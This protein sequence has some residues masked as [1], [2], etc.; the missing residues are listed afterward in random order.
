[1]MTAKKVQGLP[2]SHAVPKGVC[3]NAAAFTPSKSRQRIVHHRYWFLANRE[4]H[5]RRP[6][7]DLRSLEASAAVSLGGWGVLFF[8]FLS[9]LTSTSWYRT[10]RRTSRI[11]TFYGRLK[12]FRQL[13]RVV[14]RTPTYLCAKLRYRSN[15][16]PSAYR[17]C[18]FTCAVG[19]SSAVYPANSPKRRNCGLRAEAVKAR[20]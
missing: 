6:Y 13:G 3:S 19:S 5:M 7:V 14:L 2:R 12:A 18:G 8:F 4:Y 17:I 11:C 1:M 20:I 10:L 9:P 15:S 16:S